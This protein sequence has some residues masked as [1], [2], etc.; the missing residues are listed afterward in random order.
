V[1][2]R[3]LTD[4]AKKYRNGERKKGNDEGAVYRIWKKKC[5]KRKSNRAGNKKDSV[6]KVQDRAQKTIVELGRS[7]TVT[8]VTP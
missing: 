2:S 4:P 8:I 5:N 3:V 1:R 7:S 6:L